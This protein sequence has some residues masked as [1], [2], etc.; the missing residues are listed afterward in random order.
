MNKLWCIGGRKDCKLTS[1]YTSSVHCTLTP[2]APFTGPSPVRSPCRRI[3]FPS[4]SSSLFLLYSA[5]SRRPA[6]PS[7]ETEE[8]SNMRGGKGKL[9]GQRHLE[10]R[11]SCSSA[12]WFDGR[13][14]GEEGEDSWRVGCL[15][16]FSSSSLPSQ[17][18][19]K[20]IYIRTDGLGSVEEVHCKEGCR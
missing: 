9:S 7:A 4:P 5:C 20:S 11:L 12:R 18:I 17:I 10:T 19:L 8:E 16:F 13:L 15:F 2:R 1:L 3:V 14:C 6:R